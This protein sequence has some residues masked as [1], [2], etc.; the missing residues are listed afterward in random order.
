MK[1]IIAIIP[2]YTMESVI[3]EL[4]KIKVYR[5]T[6]SNVL[7]IGVSHT[8]V[9]RGLMETGNLVKKVRFEIAVND[10]LVELVIDAISKG[11][12]NADSDGKIFIINLEE[13]IQLGTGVRGPNAVGQ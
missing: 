9:Y 11:S 7:G 3:E 2:S 8:E 4:D 5:K 10:P 13:C 6:V 12:E 1:L